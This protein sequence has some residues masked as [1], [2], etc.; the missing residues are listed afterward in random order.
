MYNKQVQVNFNE[1]VKEQA[2]V[3]IEDLK[4]NAATYGEVKRELDKLIVTSNWMD[5]GPN[6]YIIVH[7]EAY[8][9]L[10]EEVGAITLDSVITPKSK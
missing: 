3:L 9:Q 10:E 5:G 7:K 1:Y 2:L 8:R 4:E 6:H